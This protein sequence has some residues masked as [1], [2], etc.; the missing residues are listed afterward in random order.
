VQQSGTGAAQVEQ[1]THRGM[2]GLL[3]TLWPTPYA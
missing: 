3:G 2:I 1:I